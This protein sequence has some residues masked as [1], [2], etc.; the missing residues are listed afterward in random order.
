MSNKSICF[1]TITISLFF[2]ASGMLVPAAKPKPQ[3]QFL[4]QDSLCAVQLHCDL[5]ILGRIKPV[6]QYL[7][8]ATNIEAI[9]N[10]HL[11]HD[12]KSVEKFLYHHAPRILE[13]NAAQELRN[14]CTAII[15]AHEEKIDLSIC[16]VYFPIQGRFGEYFTDVLELTAD[17]RIAF[18]FGKLP[19]QITS[20]HDS[21]ADEYSDLN[22]PILND[23]L[24]AAHQDALYAAKNANVAR[25]KV[26]LNRYEQFPNYYD[27]LELL[28]KLGN[29]TILLD[30][31]SIPERGIDYTEEV[32]TL[33]ALEFAAFY[34]H[35]ELTKLL[36]E[37]G[38]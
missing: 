2:Q 34:Q 35:E 3:M 37:H 36:L 6:C 5:Q 8:K 17:D 13:M 24:D 12:F 31:L 25:L 10:N 16:Q 33:T 20:S 18:Y 29:S 26:L 21:S 15:N 1:L 11:Y 4:P 19:G 32:N 30:Y 23:I 7:N 14:R 9:L 22:D 28:C 38:A 27:L